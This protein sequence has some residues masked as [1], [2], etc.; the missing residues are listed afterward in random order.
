MSSLLPPNRSPL[1]RAIEAASEIHVDVDL[2][3]LWNPHSCPEAALPW[4]AWALHISDGEGWR[5]AKNSEQ[6]REL[7][8]KAVILHRKKGTP[9]SIKEALKAN[10]FNGI[11]I[12]ERLPQ[13]RYDGALNH[14]GAEYYNAYG[15]AQFRVTADV[16]DSQTISAE[17]TLRIVETIHQWKPARSHLVDVQ[18]QVSVDDRVSSNESITTAAQLAQ[19]EAHLWGSRLYDGSLAF[20]QGTLHTYAGALT[21]S[22]SALH[23]GYSAA[24]ERY[25]AERESSS[26]RGSV[27]FSDRHAR[28]AL[29]DGF[30]DYGGHVD[31]GASAPVAEDLPMP[32][33]VTQHRNYDGRYA[34]AA[35]RFDGKAAYVGGFSYFGNM[36]YSGHV[37][38]T[39]EA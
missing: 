14:A 30:G 16:G 31:Y 10:G 32:I 22:S 9:W 20:N 2:A 8:D 39:L 29:F 4:L 25:D 33:V 28:S 5:L 13:N 1:E 35:H 27:E 38:T 23:N 7:L 19:E 24:G 36:P 15:W 3:S 12:Q 6:K 11:D 34:F 18:Y 17:N 21:Y 26:M 37:V